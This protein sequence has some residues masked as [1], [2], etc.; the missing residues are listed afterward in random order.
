MFKGS[1]GMRLV[2]FIFVL[3]L[4]SDHLQEYVNLIS[5]QIGFKSMGFI[6]K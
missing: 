2:T 1:A 5:I 3:L 6:I 4:L